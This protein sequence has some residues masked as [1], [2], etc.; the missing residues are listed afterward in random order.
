[1]LYSQINENNCAQESTCDLFLSLFLFL[2]LLRHV[3]YAV[4]KDKKAKNKVSKSQEYVYVCMY[5]CI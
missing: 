3:L 1:M 2:S 5:K 4:E